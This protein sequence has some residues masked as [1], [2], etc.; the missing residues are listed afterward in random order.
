MKHN[1]AQ[2]LLSGTHKMGNFP[3]KRRGQEKDADAN[4]RV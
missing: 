1:A 2:T 3:N 4:L